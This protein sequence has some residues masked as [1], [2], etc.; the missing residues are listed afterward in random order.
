M[1]SDTPKVSYCAI[2]RIAA[3]HLQRCALCKTLSVS[4][5]ICSAFGLL[6]YA[7][8]ANPTYKGSRLNCKQP[9]ETVFSGAL[10][11]K[12][13]VDGYIHTG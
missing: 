9:L 10:G 3:Y 4:R 11:L 12:F 6:G 13:S 8:R 2:F 1:Y 7:L 5:Y